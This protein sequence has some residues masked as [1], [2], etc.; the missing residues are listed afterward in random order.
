MP[1]LINIF[2]WFLSTYFF[3]EIVQLTQC[4][5]IMA[6]LSILAYNRILCQDT[7]NVYLFIFIQKNK[8]IQIFTPILLPPCLI[9]LDGHLTEV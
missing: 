3:H 1:F 5:N 4:I 6:L 7:R 2:L 8:Y 9:H